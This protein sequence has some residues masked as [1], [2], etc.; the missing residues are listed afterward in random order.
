MKNKELRAQYETFK[1]LLIMV[2]LPDTTGGR[3][4]EM[5]NVHPQRSR[6]ILR[7]SPQT[8]PSLSCSLRSPW[9]KD[10]TVTQP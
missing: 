7:W 2:W 5:M 10:S 3:E 4:G 1:L 9:N 6:A 8:A